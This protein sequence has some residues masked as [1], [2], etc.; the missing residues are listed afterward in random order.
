[1]STTVIF[2]LCVVLIA[3]AIRCIY[4]SSL[5]YNPLPFQL[6]GC[7]A[8]CMA[9]VLPGCGKR[10]D[11]ASPNGPV[12]VPPHPNAIAIKS[13]L[14]DDQ[15]YDRFQIID[16]E[17]KAGVPCVVVLGRGTAISCDWSKKTP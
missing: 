10:V 4:M 8:I 16:V 7:I 15:G 17:S 5:R 3:I 14:P 2:V 12:V 9:L 6:S 13:G 1:M 11:P